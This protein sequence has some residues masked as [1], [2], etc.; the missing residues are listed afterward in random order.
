MKET[1]TK[2]NLEVEYVRTALKQ[3]AFLLKKLLN[4]AFKMQGSDLLHIPQG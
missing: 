3:H 1:H 4:L 2:M